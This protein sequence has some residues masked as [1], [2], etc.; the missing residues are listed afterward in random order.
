MKIGLALSG[1]GARGMAHLGVIQFLNGLGV[2]IHCVAGTSI[3]AIVGGIFAT[4]NVERAYEWVKESDWKKLPR[5]FF[6]PALPVKALLKGERITRFLQ[7]MVPVRTFDECRVPFA[8]VATDLATGE[9][10]VMRDG[11]VISAI[12][13]SIAIPGIFAPVERDGR[14]LVDGGLVDP[15][16]VKACLELG[17]ERVIAVDINTKSGRPEQEKPFGKLNIV[18]IIAGSFRIFNIELTKRMLAVSPPDV[19]VQPPVND[20]MVLDFRHARRIMDAG[21]REMRRHRDAVRALLG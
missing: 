18:D 15:L 9:R 14:V 4:G 21:Y 12:R 5:L 1:G 13:A 11:D 19:L 3:G 10:V 7:E 2:P 16:P 17:A 8:A 6:D 20:V